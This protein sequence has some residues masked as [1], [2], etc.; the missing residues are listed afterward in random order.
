MK[1]SKNVVLCILII[2]AGAVLIAER[3]AVGAGVSSALKTCAEILIPS[4]FPFMMLSS[5]ALKSGVFRSLE[6][7]F[8]PFMQKVFSLSGECFSCLFF[9][10][11]GGYPVG[12]NTVSSL[13]ERGSISRNDAKHMMLFCVNAGPAF[14][15]TAVGEMML[16]SKKAGGVILLSVCLAS[17]ISGFVYSLLKPKPDYAKNPEKRYMPFSSAL[18]EAADSA[19]SGMINICIWVIVFSALSAVVSV[20]LKN[21]FLSLVFS[22]FSEVTSGIPSA[23]KLGGIPMVAASI[24]FGGFCVMLQMLPCIKKCGLKARD[25]LLF[26]IVNS[27]LSFFISKIIL[28]FVDIPADVFASF[29][30]RPW[31]FTAPSSAVLLIMCAVLIFDTVSG[32]TNSLADDIG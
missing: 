23:A 21:E 24:S 32:K 26:R 12:M 2:A 11:T 4:L 13:Y 16:G 30:A 20:F 14:T 15:V 27:V 19:C 5:F 31:S 9:G 8:S 6:K 22:S 3:T 1:K 17:L 25:Y 18:V 28:V 10:F 29:Y 7:F